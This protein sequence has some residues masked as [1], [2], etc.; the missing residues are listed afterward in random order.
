[1][2]AHTNIRATAQS[3]S[4]RTHCSQFARSHK[5]SNDIH[6]SCTHSSYV[7][8]ACMYVNCTCYLNRIHYDNSICHALSANVNRSTTVIKIFR[9][10]R[11]KMQLKSEESVH[12][13]ALFRLASFLFAIFYTIYWRSLLGIV[14][15]SM[16][17]PARPSDFSLKCVLY[18]SQIVQQ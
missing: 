5:R 2:L 9:E 13:R 3:H 15:C 8:S 18:T 16:F 6:F 1:M 11:P 10:E 14:A 4:K 17:I 7:S 12:R